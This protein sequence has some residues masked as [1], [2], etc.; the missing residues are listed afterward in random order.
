MFVHKRSE[1]LTWRTNGGSSLQMKRQELHKLIKLHDP[2]EVDEI[3]SEEKDDDEGTRVPRD[4][5][6]RPRRRE[7][8]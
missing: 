2:E 3:L 1:G 6:R 5:T 8:D 4:S 7:G